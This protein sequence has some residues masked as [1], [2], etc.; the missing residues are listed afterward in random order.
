M[1][2]Q[3]L[4]RIYR[5]PQP[6]PT[7][8]KCPHPGPGHVMAHPLAAVVF[9]ATA[10][11]VVLIGASITAALIAPHGVSPF[12]Y[13][14]DHPL[15]T[16]FVALILTQASL[17]S[18]F[19][20]RSSWPL[21][22]KA[23]AATLLLGCLW[24]LL[25]GT[26]ETTKQSPIATGAWAVCLI[27]QASAVWTAV[28]VI[29]FIS[30]YDLAAARSRFGLRHLLICTTLV[31]V[32]LGGARVLAARHGFALADV[33]DWDF[34][35]HIQA[36]AVTNATLAI[37]TYASLRLPRSWTVRTMFCI[38][39]LTTATVAAPLVF[40]AVFSKNTSLTEMRWLFGSEGVFLIA[41]LV[42]MEML[43][44]DSHILK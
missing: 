16:V 5:E 40:L 29:E 44:D 11:L 26:M 32:C 1:T 37:G 31:A 30:N 24:L 25:V 17:A 3:P 12:P 43:R 20:A 18:V 19:F 7:H 15:H 34:F 35:W 8:A 10:H 28:T 14:P 42:P 6:V 27:I 9:S 41:T 38:A 4:L 13:V 2:T 33:P 39:A 21:Y 22:L 36:A 23:L